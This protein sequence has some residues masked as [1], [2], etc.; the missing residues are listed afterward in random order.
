MKW[1]G[2]AVHF[3]AASMCRFHLATLLDNGFV[4]STVGDYHPPH[5]PSVDG[6][7]PIEGGQEIGFGRKYETMVFISRRECRCGCGLPEIDGRNVGFDAYNDAKAATAG[8][9]AMIEEFTQKKAN[10]VS[11]VIP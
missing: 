1:F 4:V 3:C 8:H 5:V 9:M 10:D 11:E 7:K 2:H 6:E